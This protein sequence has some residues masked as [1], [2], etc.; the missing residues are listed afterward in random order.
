MSRPDT[1][2]MH[3]RTL[4]QQS[5]AIWV[6][7]RVPAL[8]GAA[9][10]AGTAPAQTPALPPQ[11]LSADLSSPQLAGSTRLRFFGLDIYDAKLWVGPGFRAASY[12][13]HALG[14]ELTY[15]RSLSGRAIAERSIKE[16]R[17]AG[18]LATE[19]EQ[20]WLAAMTEAFADV[21]SGDRLTGLHL[22]A[23]GAKF[24]FNGQPR[25]TIRDPEFSRLFFGIWLSDATSE[26][27]LRAELLARTAP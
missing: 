13:Q 12:A 22:P 8:L 3:R 7:T 1:L 20:R 15:L 9:A 11:E 16:M 25:A 17:R 6:S 4:L 19:V 24:W 10:F 2:T 23:V 27:R 21:Q 5:T 18:T 14:L 26:P